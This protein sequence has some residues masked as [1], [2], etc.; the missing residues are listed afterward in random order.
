M[1]VAVPGWE[2]TRQESAALSVSLESLGG[3]APV[4]DEDEDGEPG[5]NPP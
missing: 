1:E 4:E 5:R 3:H 2:G